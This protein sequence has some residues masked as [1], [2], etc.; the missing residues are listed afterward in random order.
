MVLEIL[1]TIFRCQGVHSLDLAGVVVI[2]PSAENGQPTQHPTVLM[3]DRI[4][5]IVTPGAAVVEWSYHLAIEP[6][7]GQRTVRA[8]S[9][10]RLRLQKFVDY[11]LREGNLL[12]AR[13]PVLRHG[14]QLLA[15]KWT[16]FF[17]RRVN[18]G[19][20]YFAAVTSAAEPTGI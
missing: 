16:I 1:A 19:V 18:E 15:T 2:Q 14:V 5:R 12:P 9:R 7:A 4:V 8:I 13:M 10:L 20:E 3:R 11:L 17:F 6:A